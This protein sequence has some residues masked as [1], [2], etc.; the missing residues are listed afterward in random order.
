LQTHCRE[1]RADETPRD[2]WMINGLIPPP[3]GSDAE[4]LWA[5]ENLA[6]LY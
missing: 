4:Q 5:S 3:H 6:I 2:L 1:F